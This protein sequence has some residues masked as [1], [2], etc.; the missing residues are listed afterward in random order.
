LPSFFFSTGAVP[1]EK[2]FEHRLAAADLADDGVDFLAVLGDAAI[3]GI[4]AIP[5][6]IRIKHVKLGKIEGGNV[7][8]GAVDQQPSAALPQPV[9]WGAALLRKTVVHPK[10]AADHEQ[11]VSNVVCGTESEFSYPGVYQQRPN[12]EEEWFVVRDRCSGSRRHAGSHA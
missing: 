2:L 1:V 5:A 6:G 11:T 9:R 12:F 7:S 3:G 8:C 4:I 10:G